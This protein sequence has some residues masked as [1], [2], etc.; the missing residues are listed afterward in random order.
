MASEEILV[1]AGLA[2]VGYVAQQLFGKTLA[3][4][5]DD[6][7]KSYKS[8]RDKILEKAA[9]KVADP[10]DGAHVN[11]RV[12]RD[13][14]WNGAVTD[15]E[16]CAEY[17]GGLLA[18]SRSADGKDDSALIYVDCV[19][20][21]S[22]KQLHLHFAIYDSFQELLIKSGR[23]INPGLNSE[24]E[25]LQICFGTAELLGLGLQ[26]DIDVNIL[27]R[28]GLIAGFVKN[29]QVVAGG[30]FDYVSVIPSTFGILLYAAAS[31][32]LKRWRLYSNMKF[33]QTSSIEL[34]KLKA[35]TLD[36]LC[37]LVGLKPE[38][39]REKEKPIPSL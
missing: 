16:V 17:F 22:S 11:L 23:K 39:P 32:S 13:V 7:N 15:N 36:E 1:A 8:N 28:Q 5:G 2:G 4:M 12:A 10:N 33:D 9:K 31:N 37:V 27:V 14:L 20:S 29:S 34:P 38:S 6:L 35:L 21:L 30:K 18:G 19:K 24:L 3:E 25:A 26:P